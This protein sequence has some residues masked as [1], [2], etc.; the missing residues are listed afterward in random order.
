[1]EFVRGQPPYPAAEDA[2]RERTGEKAG[3]PGGAGEHSQA[4]GDPNSAG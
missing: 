2:G 1:M 3:R 4:T